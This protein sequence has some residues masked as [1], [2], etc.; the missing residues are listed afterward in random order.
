[1]PS[2]A[3]TL[4]ADRGLLERQSGSDVFMPAITNTSPLQQSLQSTANPE[5]SFGPCPGQHSCGSDSLRMASADEDRIWTRPQVEN[6]FETDVFN[7]GYARD[8]DHLDENSLLPVLSPSAFSLETR[9]SSH[10]PPR[11]GNLLSGYGPSTPSQA[12]SQSWLSGRPYECKDSE[13][14]DSEVPPPLSAPM[15]QKLLRLYSIYFNSSFPVV[16]EEELQFLAGKEMQRYQTSNGTDDRKPSVALIY[17]ILFVASGVS[18][19]RSPSFSEV[20]F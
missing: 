10:V 16:R 7:D 3:H 14:A 15:M 11:H 5:P 6:S 12:R 2:P 1:M 20:G 17:A 9:S 4:E 19:S 18:N 13:T 8:G